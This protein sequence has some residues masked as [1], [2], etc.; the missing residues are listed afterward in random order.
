MPRC[1]KKWM[2]VSRPS[3]AGRSSRATA[4]ASRMESTVSSAARAMP[5]SHV[6]MTKAAGVC[7]S[8]AQRPG[9][10]SRKPTAML[11]STEA[12]TARQSS[13]NFLGERALLTGAATKAAAMHLLQSEPPTMWARVDS[14]TLNSPASA[15]GK[16]ES[17]TEN[18]AAVASFASS[19]ARSVGRVARLITTARPRS[20]A[21]AEAGAGS[22]ERARG[23]E[24]VGEP[25][26]LLGLVGGLGPRARTK[27]TAV[28]SSEPTAPTSAQ[29]KASICRWLIQPPAR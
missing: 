7:R 6:P 20:R 24:R 3:S 29:P 21:E 1:G 8:E 13:T 17:F 4:W 28:G 11:S 26:P 18:A 5:P 14:S 27:P 23:G 25:P 16:A 12:L 19:S 10:G 2:K 15:M 9:R 22:S